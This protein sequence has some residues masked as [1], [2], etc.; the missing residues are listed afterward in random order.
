MKTIIESMKQ[1]SNKIKAK[2]KERKLFNKIYVWEKDPVQQEVDIDGALSKIA[3]SMPKHYF[4]NIEGI[5][6]GQFPNLNNRNLNAL[7]EDNAIYITNT[8]FDTEDLIKNI[9]HEVAHSIE[10]TYI[11]LIED[12]ETLKNE[13][14]VKRRQLKK[15][16]HLNN[17]D[18]KHQ[19][20]ENLDYD[21]KFDEY[22]YQEI[23]YPVLNTLTANLFVSPY[24]ATSY[25]EYFANGFEHYYM[26]DY[27]S[28]KSVSPK[29][30]DLLNKIE[31]L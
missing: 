30:F 8:V 24:A 25:K 26:N 13:F 27:L 29:L 16:L 22:L 10:E 7:F 1:N 28:V 2:F 18:T 12:N 3:N 19:N 21:E 17:Y 23:G 6:I 11:D 20:F 31:N 15:L 4:E 14:F 9:V 5:Y